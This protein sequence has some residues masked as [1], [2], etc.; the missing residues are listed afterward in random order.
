MARVL[1]APDGERY[2]AQNLGKAK[3]VD[4]ATAT[5][6]PISTLKSSY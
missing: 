6:I 1:V 2:T 4:R 5:N 3:L